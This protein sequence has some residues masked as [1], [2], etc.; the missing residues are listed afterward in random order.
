MGLAPESAPRG[1]AQWIFRL[2]VACG[3][4]LAWA[5]RVAPTRPAASDVLDPCYQQALAVALDRGLRFGHDV[6]FTNGPLSPLLV[7]PFQRSWYAWDL[8]GYEIVWR[9]LIAGLLFLRIVRRKG[10]WWDWV[11]AVVVC[12]LL[13]S[14]EDA[15]LFVA[16]CVALDLA[17]E[18]QSD[19]S[20][21]AGRARALRRGLAIGIFAVLAMFK[22]TSIAIAF[23]AI[24]VIA[25]HAWSCTGVKGALRWLVAA[26]AGQLALW[27]ALGQRPLDYFAYLSTSIEL[28]GGFDAAMSQPPR[29]GVL[30]IAGAALA[31]LAG[32]A[33]VFD[34]ERAGEAQGRFPADRARLVGVFAIL[35]LA[36]KSGFSRADDH[37]GSFFGAAMVAPLFLWP[38]AGHSPKRRARAGPCRL[39]AAL[40]L[41][42][43]SLWTTPA[44]EFEP[45]ELF[46]RMG[47]RV[48]GAFHW[49][50][51]PLER[52][53]RMEVAR[54]Q[55]AKQHDL[56]HMRA[57]VGDA[58]IASFGHDQGVLFLNGM[59]WWPQPVLQSFSVFTSKSARRNATAYA[60]EDGPR[61]VLWKGSQIDERWISSED[62]LSVQVL[63]SHFAPRL[64]ERGYLLLERRA[65]PGGDGQGWTGSG[66]SVARAATIPFGEWIDVPAADGPLVLRARIRPS[67]LGRVRAAIFQTPAV[68][69]DVEFADGGSHGF[70]AMTFACAEGIVLLPCVPTPADWVRHAAGRSGGGPTRLRWRS[71]APSAFERDIQVEFITAPDLA[72]PLAERDAMRATL[73]SFA[74]DVPDAFESVV[75]PDVAAWDGDP[76]RALVRAPARWTFDLEAGDHRVDVELCAPPWI[77]GE[78]SFGGV[79][80]RWVSIEDGLERVHSRGELGRAAAVGV[81]E[82]LRLGA[83]LQ[84][85][86]AGRVVLELTPLSPA[87]GFDPELALIAVR[88]LRVVPR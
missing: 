72:A 70:R 28:A 36:Y 46:L 26:F 34:R 43:A 60:R 52:L 88:G 4:L 16:G 45:S 78:A 20:A 84:L 3:A 39:I 15:G 62:P 40:L 17:L 29:A 38:F 59:N 37:T 13:R 7:T 44:R 27:V 24:G 56:P 67:V 5:T 35:L 79:V 10:G 30:A 21:S 63:L 85:P 80:A 42:G 6:V 41:G 58:T 54:E 76:A 8:I 32:F 77:A 2:A 73:L 61:F 68:G 53:E 74:G 49:V 14:T 69:I 82:L 64:H 1:A 83:D 71:D 9:G 47:A 25:L 11:A 86:R 87:A 23:A 65:R 22:V 12:A 51:H 55:L 50:T 75:E 48:N 33:W 57:I 19:D 31:L 66:R 81:S 18:P